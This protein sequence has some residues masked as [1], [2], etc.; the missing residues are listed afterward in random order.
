MPCHDEY[1]MAGCGCHQ[2]V[3]PQT[4]KSF[5]S[6]CA[7]PARHQAHCCVVCRMPQL[8]ALFLDMNQICGNFSGTLPVRSD[9]LMP[10][11]SFPQCSVLSPQPAPAPS[12]P[13]PVMSTTTQG[14]SVGSGAIAGECNYGLVSD[15]PRSPDALLWAS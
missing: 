11:N 8:Q 14:S 6:V 10:V 15:E 4:L 2:A 7:K 12:P 9:N 1:G 5:P 13:P 3:R